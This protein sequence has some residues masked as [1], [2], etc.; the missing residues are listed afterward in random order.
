MET[1]LRDV[2]YSARK[3]LHT[4]AFTAIVVGTL[5][6]AIGATTAVF[7]IVNGVLL[8]PLPLR[9]A[10]RVV[11]VSSLDRDGNRN[12]M[13]YQDFQDYRAQ[14]RLISSMAAYDNG[15]HNLTGTGGEPIRLS[16]TRVN[17]NFFDVIGVSP[18]LGRA[19]TRG[20]DAKNAA[21][22]AVLSEAL[23][24]TKFGSDPKVVGRTITIDGRP[25]TV[26]G[27]VPRIDIQS[28]TDIWLPLIPDAGDEDPSNR[29]AHYLDGIGRLAPGATVERAALEL[30]Q[31]ARTL[32]LRY[33]RTNT[34]FSATAIPLT[35]AIVGKVRPALLVML[36]GVGFVL[37]I[38]CANV[39]NL[40]LVRASTRETE[41]AVRTALGAGSRQL[42]RQLLTESM[43]LAIGGAIVG[44]SLAAWAVDG[45]QALHPAGVPRLDQVTVDGRVLSFAIV[46]AVVTGLLFGLVPAIHAS[47]TD[48]GQM[49][50]DSARGSSGR[51]GARRTRGVLVATEMALAVVLLIG[52]GLLAR[53]FL[54]LTR[55][56][57]GYRADNVVTMSV[58]LPNTKYPWDQQAINFANAVLERV[59]G[60]PDVQSA[61]LAF[62]RPLS[63]IGMRITFERTDRPPSTPDRRLVSD[64]RVVTPG[65]FSTL[66][67]PVVSG[68][69]MTTSDLDNAPPVVVVSQAFVRKYF[70]N[71]NPLGKHIVI[72]WGRQRSE[73]KADTVS[74]GG[75]IVG[76]VGDI[77]AYG[78]REQAPPILYLPYDQA[79]VQDFSL[80][81]RS[82]AAPAVIVNGARAAIKE[83]D[84][85]LPVFDVKTMT[86]ALAES[87]SQ[88]RFYAILLASFA[89]IAL[90]IAALGIYGVISYT[91]NQRTRELG[92]R[93]A[94]GAQR[95]RVLRLVIRQGMA[96]SLIGVVVGLVF[97]YV[98]TRVIASMLFGVAAADPLTFATVTAIF[99]G[100][101]WMASYLP[102]RRAA[103]VDPI[104][105]M[106]AE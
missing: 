64:V 67:I 70:P 105:A 101:A 76:V 31:I 77:K 80:L 62:G 47:R 86:D 12:P 15:T 72:G 99:V 17:A 34:R 19:F 98:L 63:D 3:L 69:A 14:S 79:P 22:T 85:D 82:S 27:V 103:T 51:R 59:R 20:E 97:A 66:R 95:Q 78:N 13:S 58:S 25:H 40:L 87:V 16:G 5:A 68:R 74:A 102:A 52:A 30:K 29:G 55:V 24:R 45:V 21:L 48:I 23:W 50:K 53:S 10:D 57:P 28:A 39:A 91:V 96:L 9:D 1:L 54:A 11:S 89:G 88:P 35:E 94:L 49:L 60:L 42:V 92:I 73:N 61:A 46:T 84:A 100:I 75:E 106:R 2:R 65:F 90:V 43:L 56:D 26:L 38:A 71:E 44:T 8:Q 36:G 32:E 18:V 37:L 83:T 81:V 93:I 104:I 41:I 7:S 33:P 6:L 4:P